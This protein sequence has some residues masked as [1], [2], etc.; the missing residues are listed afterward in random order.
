MSRIPHTGMAVTTDL[1]DT[2]K[3]I[4]PSNKWDVG[5][6]LAVWALAK[7]YGRDDV[8]YSGPMYKAMEVKAGKVFIT[9]D[10]LGGGLM[11]KAVHP[12]TRPVSDAGSTDANDLTFFTVA[13]ADGKFHPAQAKI[14]GDRVVVWSDGVPD[15][16]AVRFAWDEHA[17]PNLF[18]KAVYRQ[19]P[20]GRIPLDAGQIRINNVSGLTDG[21]GASRPKSTRTEVAVADR[22]P[23]L[24]LARERVVVLDGAMGS[25][26]QTRPLDLQRDWLGQENISEVLNFSRRMSFRRFTKRSWPSV[27]TRWRRT[28]LARTR[29]CWPK[30]TW[31]I[32]CSTT[33]RRPRRLPAAR[34]RSSRPAIAAL[35]RWFDRTRHEDSHARSHD[36]DVM[37]DSYAGRC[38][39]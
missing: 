10:H 35:R 22:K 24:E 30:R 8:V 21:V 20:F 4:H 14:D 17:E 28:R 36:V 27:V 32:A 11:T 3:D 23:F 26:L 29:S 9:F 18:N 5:H 39:G 19:F 34:A 1:I 25:N 13:S 16:T 12:T 6:R 31:P 15:P 2:W 33:T 7:T 38:A 37:E